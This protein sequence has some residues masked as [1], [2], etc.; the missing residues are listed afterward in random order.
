MAHLPTTVRGTLFALLLLA[1]A[2][3]L[4]VWLAIS[5]SGPIVWITV[6]LIAIA[7]IAPLVRLHLVDAARE[8]AYDPALGFGDALARLRAEDAL[9]VAARDAR[10]ERAS[11]PTPV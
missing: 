8:R 4:V 2:I 7:V 5:L 3:P 1:A 9:G 10:R 6:A 11:T